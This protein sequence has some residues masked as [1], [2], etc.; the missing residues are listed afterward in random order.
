VLEIDD[1]HAGALANLDRLYQMAERWEDLAAV[2]ERRV[3][4]AG[5]REEILLFRY[6]LGYLKENIFEDLPGA[7]DNY[8][9]ILWDEPT[10]E[11]ALSSL[12]RL[13][14]HIEYRREIADILEPLY[15]QWEAWQKLQALLQLKLEVTEDPIDAAAL[16]RRIGRLSQEELGDAQQAFDAYAM[17]LEIEPGD[18]GLVVQLE[19]LTGMLENWQPLAEALNNAAQNVE[20]GITKRD[21][22]LKV[23][24][25]LVERLGAY[26]IA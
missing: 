3:E 10:H 19:Q 16:L 6:Q 2:L 22:N 23:G 5:N 20:D 24:R 8:K 26:E 21:L 14:A 17:A 12:E 18:T 15:V 25:I 11:D 7:I 4:V 9:Q 13:I 1:Y